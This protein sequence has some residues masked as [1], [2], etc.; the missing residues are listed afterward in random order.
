MLASGQL[1]IL[2]CDEP[3]Q[4]AAF[5]INRDQLAARSRPFAVLRFGKRLPSVVLKF[6][7]HNLRSLRLSMNGRTCRKE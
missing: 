5:M 4:N 6:E 2:V 7:F 3:Y 1:V